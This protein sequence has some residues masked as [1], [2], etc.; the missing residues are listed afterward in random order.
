MQ[1]Y[2]ILLCIWATF[3]FVGGSML[4]HVDYVCFIIHR[5]NFKRTAWKKLTFLQRSIIQSRSTVSIFQTDDG[6]NRWRGN[7]CKQAVSKT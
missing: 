3:V 2:F 6:A 4:F 5:V 1:L 7:A